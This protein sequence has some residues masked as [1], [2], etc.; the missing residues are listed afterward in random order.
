MLFKEC[1]FFIKAYVFM[2]QWFWNNIEPH[3]T[4]FELSISHF[5]VGSFEMHSANIFPFNVLSVTLS[6]DINTRVVNL[7]GGDSYSCENTNQI[8]L[9]P[10]NLNIRRDVT[11]KHRFLAVHFSV[12]F[13]GGGDLFAGMSRCICWNSL[14]LRRELYAIS[15]STN[16]TRALFSLKSILWKLIAEHAPEPD[17]GRLLLARKY[18]G[19]FQMA[20]HRK[21]ASL[22]VNELADFCSLRSD[23]F[24]RKFKH[25]TGMTPQFF[26]H[27]ILTKAISSE[28]ISTDKKLR[29]IAESLD[30][31]SEFHMSAFFKKKT[32]FAPTDF[33]K[34]YS[35]A[36]IYGVAKPGR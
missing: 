27:D 16:K 4:L 22:S 30:F 5:A 18:A 23:V 15:A 34:K 17:P 11:E 9:V 28:L 10:C 33:R 8:L 25:D 21:S 32:G 20:R 1:V 29:E 19:L 3:S 31:C 7:T 35:V 24:S 6:P 36:T 26:L 13:P 14:Q 2:A 12:T